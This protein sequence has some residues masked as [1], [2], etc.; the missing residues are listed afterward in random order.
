MT[1]LSGFVQR[2][3]PQLLHNGDPF[4][5][6]GTNT[7]YLAYVEESTLIGALD[8][9]VSFGMNVLRTWLRPL[10]PARSVFNTGMRP[11]KLRAYRMEKTDWSG[12]TARSRRPGSA[13]SA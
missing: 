11:R 3:G 6:V 12:W 5:I 10:G 4:P 9:A 1:P 8:L 13:A 2:L 7:Y